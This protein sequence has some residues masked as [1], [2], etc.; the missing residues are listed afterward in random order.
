MPQRQYDAAGGNVLRPEPI[1]KPSR[2]L[3]AAAVGIRIEGQID[4]PHPVA[5][6]LELTAIQ[7]VPQRARDIAKAGL[8]QHGVIEQP[9]NQNHIG[10]MPN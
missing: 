8:P 6:L 4:G 2:G 1:G 9:L 3:L 10:T 5:Q 7:M